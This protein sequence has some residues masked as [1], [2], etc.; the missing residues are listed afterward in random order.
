MWDKNYDLAVNL[1]SAALEAQPNNL[2]VSLYLSKA[3]FK[4]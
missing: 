4:K 2:E 3:F 1:Y